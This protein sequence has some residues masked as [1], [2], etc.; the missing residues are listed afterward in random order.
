MELPPRVL[1]TGGAGL[2]GSHIADQLV[3]RG[4]EVVILDN[5]S[6]GRMSNI[7][8]VTEHPLVRIVRGDILDARLVDE[9]VATSGYVFHMAAAVGVANVVSDPLHVI[10]TNV[11]GTENVLQSCHH[12]QRGITVASSSE[13]YGKAQKVPF[14]EE[15]D[16]VLGPTSVRRWAYSASKAL[17]EHMAYAYA[18]Q[19][20]RAA[21]VRYFN[22]YGPRMNERA[23]GQVVARFAAQAIRGEPLT[24]H[25]DG[26]QTRCF[27]FVDDSVRATIA[28]AECD[29]AVGQALNVGSED[30]VTINRLASVIRD[31]LRSNSPIV[32]V[33]YEVVYGAD[34]EDTRR[35]APDLT[36][37]RKLLGFE[38]SIDLETGL[39]RTLA[40]CRAHYGTPESSR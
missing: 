26:Q 14:A 16:R 27:T 22:T 20:L 7:A 40:W 24:V 38:P 15:D 37:A 19:G 5:F 3:E 28:A 8:H 30:E 1:I 25:G 12:Y 10:L 39:E 6:T 32:H 4:R 36:K 21:V 31:R 9:L 29:A 17:D 35:R 18:A 2:I 13:V 33:P 11:R 34:F 23:D